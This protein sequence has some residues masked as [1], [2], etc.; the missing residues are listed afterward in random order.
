MAHAAQVAAP[1]G[2]PLGAPVVAPI[3]PVDGPS[4]ALFDAP[5]ASTSG[6]NRRRGRPPRPPEQAAHEDAAA[7][8]PG[9]R[10]QPWP[11]IRRRGE[12]AEAPAA[13][14]AVVVPETCLSLLRANDR[15]D[16]PCPLVANAY[17]VEAAAGDAPGGLRIHAKVNAPQRLREALRRPGL[18]VRPIQLGTLADPYLPVEREQRL[19]RALL[20]VL[21]E[22]R[23]P[24][25]LLTASPAVVRDL[26]LLAGLA[27]RR[28]AVVLMRLAPS[29]CPLG[30]TGEGDVPP[31]RLADAVPTP[32]PAATR[33]RPRKSTAD[34][35]GAALRQQLAASLWLQSLA[36][37]A[38]AGIPVGVQLDLAADGVD[39]ADLL[40]PVADPSRREAWLALFAQLRAAGACCW[41]CNLPG[42]R[43]DDALALS[44]L[45]A[46]AGLGSTLP[47]LDARP[48]VAPAAV[49]PAGPRQVTLF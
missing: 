39:A 15:H 12:A 43:L 27:A 29:S 10:E 40:P 13:S 41:R 11:G 33:G 4:L 48:F 28:Q 20:E 32:K 30:W 36:R 19:T 47:A 7:T 8:D 1:A 37:L 35:P 26:D 18:V 3:R 2:S 5:D 9:W 6:R 22:A 14:P 31:A 17:R 49:V 42:E 25:G 21:A 45:A 23:H 34:V 46:Q 38:R 24:V 44:D 16:L